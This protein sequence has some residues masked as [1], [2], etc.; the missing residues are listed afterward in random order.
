MPDDGR[1]QPP[2]IQ[3]RIFASDEEDLTARKPVFEPAEARREVGCRLLVDERQI[4]IGDGR[5]D[6]LRLTRD[7]RDLVHAGRNTREPGLHHSRE[8]VPGAGTHNL[9]PPGGSG[10]GQLPSHLSP[11]PGPLEQDTY[12]TPTSPQR[13]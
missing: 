7:T 9:A 2:R 4:G 11:R 6:R 3:H 5:R 12:L 8:G 1:A 10:A 13:H